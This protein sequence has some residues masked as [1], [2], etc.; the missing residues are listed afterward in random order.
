LTEEELLELCP[1]SE[2]AVGIPEK[3]RLTMRRRKALD[4]S[5]DYFDAEI[6]PKKKH[7]VLDSMP[8]KI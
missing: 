1:E 6:W 5:K 4:I 2:V 3:I 8:E 7:K